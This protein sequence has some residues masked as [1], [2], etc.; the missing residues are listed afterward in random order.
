MIKI[1]YNSIMIF[2]LS[3]LFLLLTIPF[4]S[5]DVYY[6]VPLWVYISLSATIIYAIL[7]ILVIEKRWNNLKETHE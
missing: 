5:S 6:G 4:F 7:L 3:F 1:I 2:K